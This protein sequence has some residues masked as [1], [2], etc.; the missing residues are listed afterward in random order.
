MAVDSR[1]HTMGMSVS[2][3]DRLWDL[4]STE[5]KQNPT[6]A[7]VVDGFYEKNPQVLASVCDSVPSP[8]FIFGHDVIDWDF[9]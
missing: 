5:R 1:H 3:G 4:I 9:G 6:T 2:G 7:E 8:C